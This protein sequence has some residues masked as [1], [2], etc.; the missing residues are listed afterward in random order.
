MADKPLD[1][2]NETMPVVEDRKDSPSEQSQA[3]KAAANTKNSEDVIADET[4]D[5]RF[6]ATDN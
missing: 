6:Q 3:E 2:A 4:I 1:D 5:D